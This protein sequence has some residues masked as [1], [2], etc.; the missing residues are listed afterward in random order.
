MRKRNYKN[1]TYISQTQF[2]KLNVSEK[3]KKDYYKLKRVVKEIPKLELDIEYLKDEIK[4]LQQKKEKYNKITTELYNRVNYIFDDYQPNIYVVNNIK[5][6]KSGELLKFWMINVKYKNKTKPI[7]LGSDS[8]V[9]E[10]ICKIHKKRINLKED[11]L[12]ELIKY[13]LVDNIWDWVIKEKENIFNLKVNM[14]NFLES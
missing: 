6:S 13:E 12:R 9:R 5:E 2:D 4:E 7:Y 3:D 11:K 10:K 1:L 14:D 8:K